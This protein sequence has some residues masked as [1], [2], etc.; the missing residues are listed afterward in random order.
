M[1]NMIT[2][3]IL[4]TN[5]WTLRFRK[6]TIKKYQVINAKCHNFFKISIFLTKNHASNNNYLI[7]LAWQQVS[8]TMPLELIFKKLF[9]S[10]M[11]QNFFNV[12]SML[13]CVLVTGD[14][15]VGQGSLQWRNTYILLLKLKP[16]EIESGE[17]VLFYSLYCWRNV[18]SQ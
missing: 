12:V 6:F 5:N 8:K 3:K 18:Y 17:M 16:E 4:K 2:L 10:Q 15:R 9:Q 7:S 14:G 11:N 13:V 1:T